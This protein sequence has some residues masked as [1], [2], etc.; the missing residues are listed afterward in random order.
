MDSG[1]FL[2]DFLGPAAFGGRALAGLA[3]LLGPSALRASVWPDGHPF[4]PLGRLAF[5][6]HSCRLKPAANFGT[7]K[8][9]FGPPL[10]CSLKAAGPE[11]RLF[12]ILCLPFP[13]PRDK[14][15]G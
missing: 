6:H 14:P 5:G 9:D 13:L 10:A 15:L 7:T 3:G 12:K 4:R 8:L 1:A 11:K 2:I